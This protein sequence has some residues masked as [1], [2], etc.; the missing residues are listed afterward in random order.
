MTRPFFALALL[1]AGF[2]AARNRELRQHRRP[3]TDPS[4]AVIQNAQ[5]TV[6]RTDT[7]QAAAQLTDREGR[8]RFAYLRI[9]SYEISVAKN[10]FAGVTQAAALGVGA[11]LS[12]P[13]LF[14]SAQPKP[15]LSSTLNLP[16]LKTPAA[17]LRA[18]STCGNRQ[19]A[20]ERAQLPRPCAARSGSVAHQYRRRRTPRLSDKR[21]GES[22]PH[23]P[24]LSAYR[25]STPRQTS[26]EHPASRIPSIARHS[27][28]STFTGA[29]NTDG[30]LDGGVSTGSQGPVQEEDTI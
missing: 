7:N 27:L 2:A 3:R 29:L 23:P 19:P 30:D 18:P 6:R 12:C 4:G 26:S 16:C 24:Y 17:R 22:P 9:G 1:S 15:A 25:R 20:S 5:V 28:S 10:G 13:S 14:R 11:A 8:F 21:T